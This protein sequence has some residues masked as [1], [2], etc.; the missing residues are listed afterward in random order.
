MIPTAA[1]HRGDQG[2]AQKIHKA[3]FYLPYQQEAMQTSK[4]EV[5]QKIRNPESFKPTDQQS[6]FNTSLNQFSGQMN[7]SAQQLIQA[8]DAAYNVNSNS[9]NGQNGGGMTAETMEWDEFDIHGSD[10]MQRVYEDRLKKAQE[11]DA[12]NNKTAISRPT[13]QQPAM[14]PTNMNP[15][16]G[17]GVQRP[18]M[19]I[20]S[21]DS[22]FGEQIKQKKKQKANETVKKGPQPNNMRL[23]LQS[24]QQY[25]RASTIPVGGTL[26]PGMTILDLSSSDD[27][28]PQK[29]K[30]KDASANPDRPRK[31]S[32]VGPKVVTMSLKPD[33][34]TPL[35]MSMALDRG[36][37]ELFG[38]MPMFD[39]MVIEES[40]EDE[41]DD[42][43]EEDIDSR[44]MVNK[45]MQ[46]PVRPGNLNV[47][48]NTSVPDQPT[49]ILSPPPP[50]GDVTPT[51]ALRP[52]RPTLTA[53]PSLPPGT[54]TSP[55]APGVPGVAG[56]TPRPMA[57]RMSLWEKAKA[58]PSDAAPAAPTVAPIGINMAPRPTIAIPKAPTTT[59]TTTAP[60]TTSTSTFT[61]PALSTNS[62][63]TVATPAPQK[64]KL[65]F[66]FQEVI[67]GSIKATSP[68]QSKLTQELN[69]S[70]FLRN[71]KRQKDLNPRRSMVGTQVMRQGP[72]KRSG[73]SKNVQIRFKFSTKP[74]P[75]HVF[76][77]MCVDE[78][79]QA[80]LDAYQQARRDPPL[81]S[82][83]SMDYHLHV[84]DE[85]ENGI[86]TDIPPFD[87]LQIISKIDL[88]ALCI[89]PDKNIGSRK[90]ITEDEYD[91]DFGEYRPTV[92]SPT[93]G[94]Q[95]GDSILST[96]NK[97]NTVIQSTP[98][99]HHDQDT[100]ANLT[101]IQVSEDTLTTLDSLSTY[102]HQL[103]SQMTHATAGKQT[104]YKVFK[105]NEKGKRQ[106][107]YFGLDRFNIYNKTT[108][109]SK[110]NTFSK[111]MN[112]SKTE[113][114][115][116]SIIHVR[117]LP[118]S[119]TTFQISY[120]ED[121]SDTVT[122]R[123]YEVESVM[124]CAEIV[125]KLRYLINNP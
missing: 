35:S 91:S 98:I 97:S 26:P 89:A 17:N 55:G 20:D 79:I 15:R 117:V 63:A 115:I 32:N 45:Q 101:Q 49:P 124:T 36:Q 61:K 88:G 123:G 95:P 59:A 7:L 39:D 102:I 111:L 9:K 103:Y 13:V 109:S 68:T 70:G 21:D 12:A 23:N 3:V 10:M 22:D 99:D 83:L 77:D 56:P 86:D 105:I 44:P 87:R 73:P 78:L 14:K 67:V 27:D 92:A 62:S 120:K 108:P 110:F 16:G 93:N 96:R 11:Q 119:L 112:I 25:R 94:A 34:S 125:A 66:G 47:N 54:T 107:R 28:M 51:H 60:T 90:L 72:A 8:L 104:E 38:A 2:D 122:S 4:D 46:R 113:R 40:G 121:G 33:Q 58:A 85:D 80:C 106:E 64:E 69:D 118:E 6:L 116:K 53:N 1:L 37:N 31:F 48:T 24:S 84:W 81:Q 30:K 41:A 100:Y 43:E 74:L 75:V 50:S 82:M 18:A 29:G 57:S 71:A 42:D 52:P 114:P 76:N 5:M 65:T 19:E